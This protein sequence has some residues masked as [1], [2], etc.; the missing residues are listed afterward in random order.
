MVG[1]VADGY[2]TITTDA[3]LGTSDDPRDW[4]LLS[5]GNVNPFNLQNLGSRSL[6]DEAVLGK[7]IIKSFYGKGPNYSYWNGCSQGGRQ[8]LMLAQ[9]YP[10]AYDGIAVGAPALYWT[11]L[12][13]TIQWP[14]QYMNQLGAEC[15]YRG[16]CE[17]V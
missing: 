17:R 12:F 1:A 4:A 13:A 5:P 9:R 11:K 15:D 2:A 10:D 3:G 7:A 14:Q 16:R 8:G 6:G